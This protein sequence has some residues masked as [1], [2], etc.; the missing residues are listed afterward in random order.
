MSSELPPTDFFNGISF[1][2]S[3]YQSSSDDYLTAST[4]KKIFLS[5][6]IAQGD[7]LFASNITLQSTLTDKNGS[8][9]TLAQVLTSTTT[10]T[11]WQTISVGGT[12]YAAYS[13]TATL[14]TLV[15]TT[16]LVVVSGATVGKTITVPTGYPVGQKIQIKNTGTVVLSISTTVSVFIYTATGVATSVSLESGDVANLIYTG[17]AWIQYTPS[18]TFTKTQPRGRVER[19]TTVNYGNTQPTN[20]DQYDPIVRYYVQ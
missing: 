17:F 2:K 16:L 7:E 12:T 11:A 9:G 6:P 13:A 5:Y 4:G 10:G 15:N 18:N 8:V 3:F 1:N 19:Y 14:S 20:R